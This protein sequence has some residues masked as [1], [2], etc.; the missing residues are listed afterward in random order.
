MGIFEPAVTPDEHDSINGTSVG[1]PR[2]TF[3]QILAAKKNGV[4]KAMHFRTAEKTLLQH[5]IEQTSIHAA[6]TQTH[7]RFG[8]P[9]CPQHTS[10]TYCAWEGSGT[11]EF[12]HTNA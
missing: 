12:Q 3:V 8:N 2:E 9:L 5:Y 11:A 1:A 6:V 10:D 7:Q 4:T